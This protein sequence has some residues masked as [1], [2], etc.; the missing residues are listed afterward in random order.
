M[1]GHTKA[2]NPRKRPAQERSRQTVAAII[3]STAHVLV[4]HGY[5]GTTTARVAERAGASIGSVYQY[6][7]NKES[8][9]GALVEQ[10]ALEILDTMKAA[11]F[12]E[13]H[14]NLSCGLRCIIKAAAAAHLAN[15]ALHKVLSEQVPHV[16]KHGL[17]LE[18]HRKIAGFIET[19]LTTY[20]SEVT[21]ASDLALASVVVETT[22]EALIHK[23]VIDRSE[24]LVDHVFEDEVL[25]LLIGYL[26]YHP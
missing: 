17:A 23:A 16:G 11:V 12:E 21:G 25:T 26:T 18:T 13:P 7:P 10:H 3:T 20:S 15:P 1:T 19:M 8:L 9:I 24:L 6:F 5:E 2:L 14:S 22:L 4:R